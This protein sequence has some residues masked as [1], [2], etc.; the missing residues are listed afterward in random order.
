MEAHP[1]RQEATGA[2]IYQIAGGKRHEADRPLIC[3]HSAHGNLAFLRRYCE[4]PEEFAI[5]GIQAAHVVE[6]DT[7]ANELALRYADLVLS[8][9]PAGPYRIAGY[10]AGAAIALELAT[11]LQDAGHKVEFVGLLDVLPLKTSADAPSTDELATQRLAEIDYRVELLGRGTGL[12]EMTDYLRLT[13]SIEGSLTRDE[14]EGHFVRWAHLTL[15][16]NVYT[17]PTSSTMPVC[18]ISSKQRNMSVEL[19]T[20]ALRETWGLTDNDRATVRILPGAAGLLYRT[21]SFRVALQNE[22][23]SV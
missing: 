4:Q 23:A 18:V 15:A 10:C 7:T 5:W 22:L 8:G 14:I 3:V 17:P 19:Q 2:A 1:L 20:T 6:P 11:I 21:K 9:R 13:D 12:V 16:G